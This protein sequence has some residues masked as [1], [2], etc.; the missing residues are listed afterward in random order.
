MKLAIV[1][2]REFTDYDYMVRNI[3]KHIDISK[4]RVIISG[5]AKGADHL[6][7]RFANDHK[8]PIIEYLPDWKKYGKKAGMIRNKDIIDNSNYVIAFWN[9]Q[10][11]GTKDSIELAK[12]NNLPLIIIRYDVENLLDIF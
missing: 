11:V 7:K 5:G 12:K 6:A 1:G 2:S 9:G 8:I 10:S 4:I 3:K